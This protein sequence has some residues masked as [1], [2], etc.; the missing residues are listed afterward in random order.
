MH[1]MITVHQPR[2]YQ[3]WHAYERVC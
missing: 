2:T 1:S 3:R